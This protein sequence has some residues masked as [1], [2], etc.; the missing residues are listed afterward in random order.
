MQNITFKK[1]K[2]FLKIILIVYVIGGIAL[3]FFQEKILFHPKKLP[4]G[5]HYVFDA[6][7]KQFDLA[8]NEQKTLSI[9]QFT[10]PA[11]V[12]KGVVLYFHGNRNNIGRYASYARHFT[13]NHYEV[14]MM[15]YPGFGKSTGSR[16]E[17]IIYE[18]A[19]RLYLM[20]RS[21]F[22]KDSIILYG[23]SLGSGVAAQLAAEKDCKRL[24]LETP[25]YSIDDLMSHYAFMYPAGILSKYHFPTYQFLEK[26]EA[27]VS[28]LHGT[29]DGIIPFSQSV[30]LKNKFPAIQLIPIRG[31]SHND[32]D[33]FPLFQLSLDSLLNAQ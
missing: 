4:A 14:W 11:D 29:G 8:V 23:K 26:V 25:Y 2:F 19:A 21:R 7:F 12:C 10:V 17:D 1:V 18:D 32:L 13:R 28:I 16:T 27:P 20:A 9:V 30:K 6:P 33:S 24:V 3:Y 5:Y 22:A 31:G 15:D